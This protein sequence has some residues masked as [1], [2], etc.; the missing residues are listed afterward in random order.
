MSSQD[1]YMRLEIDQLRREE[2]R[3]QKSD[4]GDQKSELST[5]SARGLGLP[6]RLRK[7]RLLFPFVIFFY[8]LFVKG[9]IRDGWAGVYYAF[10]RMLA[11]IL[12]ALYLIEDEFKGKAL[13]AKGQVQGAGSAELEVRDQTSEVGV[14]PSGVRREG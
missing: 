13:R 9:G 14:E 3:D 12:L 6:D 1:R 11:E 4:I 10:Q 2:I 7:T 8:C 5:D